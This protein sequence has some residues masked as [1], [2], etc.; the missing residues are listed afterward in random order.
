MSKW[1]ALR[2]DVLAEAQRRKGNDYFFD[3]INRIDR[4]AWL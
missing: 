2:E 3:R 1:N 4:I